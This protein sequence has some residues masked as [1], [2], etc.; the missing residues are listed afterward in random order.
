VDELLALPLELETD[1][2]A[3][4]LV[5]AASAVRKRQAVGGKAGDLTQ[6]AGALLGRDFRCVAR[7]DAHGDD[8]EILPG[9]GLGAV[10]DVDDAVE[11]ERAEV[12]AA[13]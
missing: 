6:V 9:L 1:E 12:R 7:V 10:Q 4:A 11:Q 13:K 2:S 5:V 8:L 3:R